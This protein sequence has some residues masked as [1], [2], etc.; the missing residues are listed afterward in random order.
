MDRQT[1]APVVPVVAAAMIM[2]SV[3]REELEPQTKDMLEEMVF[4]LA[5]TALLAAGA[6]LGVLGKMLLSLR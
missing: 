5:V 6:V 1:E 4:R 2:E 3:L